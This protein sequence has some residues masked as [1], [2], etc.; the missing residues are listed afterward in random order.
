LSKASALSQYGIDAVSVPMG[1]ADTSWIEHEWD[2][3]Q[4]FKTI[5]LI[6]D[7]DRAGQ[8]NVVNIANRLGRWRCHNV[9]LPEK[10]ANDCLIKGVELA[11]ITECIQN[12]HEFEISNLVSA[13]YF[14]DEILELFKDP[15]QLS[16]TS[17]GFNGLDKILRGWRMEELTLWS[18]SN[19]SGKSTFLN[20][21][22]INLARNQV[23]SCIASLEMPPSRYLR[24]AICQVAR[25]DKPAVEEIRETL[26]FLDEYLYVVNAREEID[27]S[28]LVNIFEYAARKYG[29][30]H[31]F[32]DSLMRVSFP[33]KDE[34]KEHTKFCNDLLAFAKD[35]QIHIH[36]VAH[37]R[38]GSKDT[39]TPGKVDVSGTSNLTNLAHNVLV[40]WRPND[41]LRDKAKQKGKDMADNYILV[42]KNREW[43][44]EGKVMFRFNPDTK[45]FTEIEKNT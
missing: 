29:V 16:G 15:R 17:T 32:I 34:I 11:T 26:K 5:Y 12:A 43:G 36:L 24:W 39:Y 44:T 22:I 30:K 9:I 1:V 18:G 13:S 25:K 10:D 33:M 19:G 2:W 40:L 27:S 14:E 31:F 8:E 23:R 41:E 28:E 6:F 35:H 42:R 7:N 3:L 4:Q 20:E 45:N 37:P 38:K 21:V